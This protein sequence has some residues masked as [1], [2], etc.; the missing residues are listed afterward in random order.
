MET[1][2]ARARREAEKFFEK[3][4]TGKGLDIG[5]GNDP[6]MPDVDTFDLYQGATFKG[7]AETLDEIRDASY[8]WVYS[9][10][11]LEHLDDPRKALKNWWRVVKPGGYLII[12]VPHRDL[13]EK[14]TTLPS[15]FNLEH[16]TYWLAEVRDPGSPCT[17]TLHDVV[18]ETLDGFEVLV[19]RTC[20]EGTTNQ[21][22]PEEHANGE[23]SIEMVLKKI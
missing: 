14:K 9:S 13:Y 22:K 16:K 11:C 20:S 4:C 12:V 17:L 21:D 23:F 3:F 2:K 7:N 18:E 19:L 6:I 10:H 15:R 1:Q 5:A 8:D